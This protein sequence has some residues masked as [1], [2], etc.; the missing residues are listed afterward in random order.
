MYIVKFIFQETQLSNQL[1]SRF[2][3]AFEGDKCRSQEMVNARSD[4]VLK[5]ICGK[6]I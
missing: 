1:E 6:N 4:F 5:I 3:A 2:S